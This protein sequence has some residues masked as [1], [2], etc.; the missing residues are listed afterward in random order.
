MNHIGKESH[1]LREITT[2]LMYRQHGDMHVGFGG[3]MRFYRSWNGVPHDL[4][5]FVAELGYGDTML[6]ANCYARLQK[7]RSRTWIT[8]SAVNAANVVAQH[9]YRL[10][11][12]ASQGFDV[13]LERNVMQ[14][15]TLTAGYYHHRYLTAVTKK[16]LT[17]GFLVRGDMHL[18]RNVHL[19]AEFKRDHEAGSLFGASLTVDLLDVKPSQRKFVRLPISSDPDGSTVTTGTDAHGACYTRDG[20]GHHIIDASHKY[21]SQTRTCTGYSR[22]STCDV[23]A[24][25][26]T[27]KYNWRR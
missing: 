24:N 23:R 11:E 6:T 1:G 25:E 18:M 4:P 7:E 20:S 27:G 22:Y 2:G 19:G 17:H 26:R 10:T 9:T 3:M 13:L 16:L 12:A 14:R 5:R 8:Q 15:G 21:N